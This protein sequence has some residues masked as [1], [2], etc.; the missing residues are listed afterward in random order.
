[1]NSTFVFV[2]FRGVVVASLDAAV[3]REKEAWGR[4][5]KKRELNIYGKQWSPEDICHIF[6]FMQVRLWLPG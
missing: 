2:S 3:Q 1:M 4:S 6:V 5:R